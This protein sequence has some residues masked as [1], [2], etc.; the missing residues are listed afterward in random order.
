MGIWS[1]Q[2]EF[3]TL[4]DHLELKNKIQTGWVKMNEFE[5][6]YVWYPTKTMCAS[7]SPVQTDTNEYLHFSRESHETE[8]EIF[9]FCFCLSSFLKIGKIKT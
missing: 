9:K 2:K 7:Q 6:T 1:L 8:A 4:I 3:S 5:D